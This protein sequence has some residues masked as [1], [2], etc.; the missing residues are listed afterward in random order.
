[1]LRTAHIRQRSILDAPG[2]GRTDGRVSAVIP[3]RLPKVGEPH[4]TAKP[5]QKKKS[6]ARISRK[7]ASIF[8]TTLVLFVTVAVIILYV[9]NIIAINHLTAEI[10]TREHEIETVHTQSQSLRS[11][12]VAASSVDAITSQAKALGLLGAA[13]AP[14]PLRPR[15]AQ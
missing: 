13:R 6:T 4:V 7:R 14:L 12:I 8:N 15:T 11:E 3:S 5:G 10:A 2:G 9:S 1:M